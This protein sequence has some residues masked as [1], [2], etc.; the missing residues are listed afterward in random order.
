M[1]YILLILLKHLYIGENLIETQNPNNVSGA[2][3]EM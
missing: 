1:K 2:K 3:K